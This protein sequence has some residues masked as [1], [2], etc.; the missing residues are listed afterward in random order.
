MLTAPNKSRRIPVWA[1][2][3]AAVVL[4]L[5][6]LGA[7]IRMFLQRGLGFEKEAQ[8][9]V[10]RQEDGSL[11]L[12]WPEV[13]QAD[14]Y[15]IRAES[16]GETLLE[17]KVHGPGC[18]L[19]APAG[20]DLT[21]TVR[22]SL[23]ART[24]PARTWKVKDLAETL[25]PSV[26]SFE[27]SVETSG[28]G[29]R[30]R[31]K[32]EGG[33][34]FLLY[35][36]E[37]EQAWPVASSKEESFRLPVG[38]QT[39]LTLPAYGETLT[40][41]AGYGLQTG[42]VVLCG[43]LSQPVELKRSDF[44][45]ADIQLRAVSEGD[46]I[47]SFTWNEA[48]GDYYILQYCSED[49]PEWTDLRRV[50][51]AEEPGC[52]VKLASGTQEKLRVIGMSETRDT[53]SQS[54]ELELT[55]DLSALYATVW[56]IQDLEV[57]RDTQRQEVIGTAPAAQAFCV[58]DQAGG[59]FRIRT[60]EG[61]GYIDSNYCLINLPDYM[62]ELCSYDITNSYNS[63]YTVHGYEIPTVTGT[64]ITGYEGMK[65]GEG[66]YLVPL[67]YP[68]AQK[69]AAAAQSA[70]ADGYRLKIYDAY[71]PR[72]ASDEIYQVTMDHLY[73]PVPDTTY[74]GEP[75]KDLPAGIPLQSQLEAPASQTPSGQEMDPSGLNGAE[76]SGPAQT[77]P[78]P[79]PT[80]SSAASA[81]ASSA[82][83]A[84]STDSLPAS[85]APADSASNGAGEEAASA[86]QQQY[87]TYSLL[88]TNGQYHLGSFLA[89]NGSTHNLGIAMDLTLERL[90]TREELEM[91]TDIH[92]LS[93]YAVVD[94][95]ND[96]ANRLADYMLGA[97]FGPLSTEWWHFQDDD[98]RATLSLTT[99]QEKGVSLEGWHQDLT[100][101]YYCR[102]DGS[103]IRNETVELDGE[104]WEFDADGYA[105]TP[106]S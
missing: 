80:D 47:Y 68:T 59:M 43:P 78:S 38:D 7:G 4:V 11:L 74:S 16:G 19:P 54:E 73:D 15:Q 23:A 66:Q 94:N 14:G 95:N 50:E 45:P 26:T 40:F 102:Q 91:Q 6:L 92:D 65:T 83:A 46:N 1:A 33:Q 53:L 97:G 13:E 56:P 8:L 25:W 88:M 105:Q 87:L 69:L 71:R 32:G 96:N 9:V 35:Q 29:I 42:D 93:H 57:Y 70:R 41:A 67:L 85:S 82:P 5:A 86:P 2:A 49:I 48:Q 63:L 100:G 21:V 79:A 22:A 103:R 30:F 55:T 81:P 101:W 18:T 34:L 51:P 39:G 24:G 31:W 61:Y 20:E 10:C 3:V 99:Y 36:M 58:V 44:L 28:A 37:G 64:V 84:G 62:G 98:T 17:D 52:R 106:E 27:A 75:A 76:N 12:S 90:D 72:Q 60:P 89:R 104:T 77:T